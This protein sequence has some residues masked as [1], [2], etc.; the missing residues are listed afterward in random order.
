MNFKIG[1]IVKRD[2]N[3]D[4]WWMNICSTHNLDPDGIFTVAGFRKNN[5]L[6]LEEFPSDCS[7]VIKEF[8]LAKD[9]MS[10]YQQAKKLIGKTVQQKS[11]NSK[12][13][14]KQVGLR[15]DDDSNGLS[16]ISSVSLEENG[17]AVVLFGSSHNIPYE[18]SVVIEEKPIT[19][20]LNDTYEAVVSKDG[21]RVGCQ[22][23]SH[24]VVNELKKAI[25]QI[26]KQ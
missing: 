8:S 24:D 7:F 16:V 4:H 22:T 15:Y 19:V 6:K 25:E 13:K 9:P 5:G 17:Y 26:N 12:F 14:V 23:F 3:K 18:A 20:K 21:I 1:D 10:E 2:S 11:G